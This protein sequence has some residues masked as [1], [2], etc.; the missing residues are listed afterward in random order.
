MKHIQKVIRFLEKETRR[1]N[2]KVSVFFQFDHDEFI[3]GPLGPLDS[4]HNEDTCVL[5]NRTYPT[6]DSFSGK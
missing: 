3:W 6:S 5:G 2:L 1:M 4:N